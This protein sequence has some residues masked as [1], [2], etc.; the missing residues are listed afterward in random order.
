[1]YAWL[2][3][4]GIGLAHL[5][6]EKDA[7]GA[8]VEVVLGRS[9]GQLVRDVLA[10]SG[11]EVHEGVYDDGDDLHHKLVVVSHP[12]PGGGEERFV[13]T[14]SDN[15]TTR[16]LDRPE[17][18]LQLR[19]GRADFARYRRWIDALVTRAEREDG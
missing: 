1:M 18:L 17:V 8:D 6:A 16:S 10:G 7:A 12:A 11:V 14:G 15:W 2:A 9:V 5:L 19:P 4:R 3:G 13:L